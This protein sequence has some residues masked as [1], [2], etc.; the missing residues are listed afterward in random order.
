MQARVTFEIDELDEA[1][2]CGWSVV[3]HGHAELLDDSELGLS[4]SV[5]TWAGLKD[6]T[7]VIRPYKVTGRRVRPALARP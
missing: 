4:P 2:Q 5:G 7:A 6:H 1:G 3:V